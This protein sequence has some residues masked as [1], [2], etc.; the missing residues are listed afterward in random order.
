MSRYLVLGAGP[1]G[2][3]AAALLSARGDDV[4]VV[5]RSGAVPSSAVPAPIPLGAASG[6][7]DP[8]SSTLHGAASSPTP[9]GLD[10][11]ARVSHVT[12]DAA[13]PARLTE[14]ADGAVAILNAASPAYDRWL[15]E[16]PALAAGALIA[17]ERTGAVLATVSNTYGYGPVDGPLTEDLPLAATGPKGRLRALLWQEALAAHDAGRVRATEVRPGSYVCPGPNSPLGERVTPRVLAGRSVRVLRSAD[18]PHTWTAPLD[19]ARLLVIV[20]DDERA[21]GRPWHVP[22]NPPRTQREAVADLCRAAGV[23]PVAVGEVPPVLLRLLG[24]VNPVVRQLP[25]VAY[26]RERPL[27][28]DST[29]AQRTFGLAPTPWDEVLDGLVRAYRHQPAT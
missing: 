10:P 21:W 3:A 2:S 11:T 24:V 25:E 14:L 16:W 5:T 29:A 26:Q 18:Q 7:A 6:G 20:A 19:V 22:S 12:A 4:V 17:A 28:V 15:A 1:V 9:P 27:L 8:H 23:A 13:D